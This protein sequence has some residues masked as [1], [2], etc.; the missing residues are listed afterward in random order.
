[1]H[2]RIMRNLKLHLK[3]LENDKIQVVIL[4][5]R[6]ARPQECEKYVTIIAKPMPYFGSFAYFVGKILLS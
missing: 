1:M 5:V 2:A 6:F 4:C 3:K